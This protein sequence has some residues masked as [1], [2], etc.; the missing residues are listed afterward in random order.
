M[1]F[2]PTGDLLVAE[3]NSGTVQRYNGTTGASMGAFA[4]GN[5]IN[6][7]EG[8]TIHNGDL[9]I[10]NFGNNDVLR[11]NGST[12][13]FVSQF[14]ASGSGGLSGPYDLEF[15]PDGNLYVGSYYNSNVLKFDGTTGAFVSVFASDPSLVNTVGITFKSGGVPHTYCTAGTSSHGCVAAIGSTGTPS[16]SAATSFHIDVAGVEG[17][18]QGILFYGINN[19]GFSP[20]PWASGSTSYLCVKNP[21]QRT[22]VQNSGGTLNLCTGHLGLDWNAY[23]AAHPSAL[24]AP[25]SAGQHVF[26]QA[27]FRDPPSP[28]TTMLSDALEFTVGP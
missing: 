4:S 25:F 10:A 23:V 8:I 16:A 15:G 28:K 5:N 12:G 1:R 11:F 13:A 26:A 22:G 7:P 6:Q 19:T 27:W 18:K 2:G 9:Y 20:H 21:S 24:G 17:Q 14:V 3:Q